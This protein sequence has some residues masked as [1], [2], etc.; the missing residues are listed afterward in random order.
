VPWFKRALVTG[1]TGFLGGHLCDRLLAEGVTIRAPVRRTGPEVEALRAAGVEVSRA[2]LED[3][4][5]LKKAAQG[6]EVVFHVAALAT[7]VA[8]RQSFERTNV[9][10]TRNV[11]A[12]AREAGVRRLVFVS[13][14]SV[15]LKN[16]DRVG[17]D[18]DQPVPKRFIDHYSRS[19]AQSELDLLAANGHGIEAVIVRAPWIWGERDNRV[20]KALALAIGKGQYV[21]VGDGQNRITTCH[22][23]NVSAGL[24]AAADS[25]RAPNRVYHVAD[26]GRPTM[27]EFVSRLCVAGGLDL[28]QRRVPYHLAYA[29][30]WAADQIRS[31]GLRAPL[32]LSRPYVIHAGRITDMNDRR[33]RQELGYRPAI[34]MDEG[35]E[36]MAAWITDSGGLEAALKRR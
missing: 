14:S 33:I 9:F 16:A 34:S 1:A 8:P 15:T 12:A 32:M 19:K 6:V 30:A 28:P 5:G 23:T 11:L 13:S 10:G 17:E 24:L 31:L 21:F 22:A 4:A 2:G 20:F 35:F 26:D 7:Y 18:E 36:R 27:H 3:V 29:A 25:P